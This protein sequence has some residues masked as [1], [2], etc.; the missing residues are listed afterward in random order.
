[1]STNFDS[2]PPYK[3][4]IKLSNR[5][6]LRYYFITVRLR[7]RL[8]TVCIAYYY[9]IYEIMYDTYLLLYFHR[10]VGIIISHGKMEQNNHWPLNSTN[11]TKR[12]ENKNRIMC[13]GLRSNIVP[14][15][16]TIN[17]YNA[18]MARK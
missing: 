4:Q 6:H 8:A 3:F 7:R 9:Y 16:R 11:K 15:D 5:G 1:M 17:L 13:L 12:A 14:V 10:N 18:L 2:T